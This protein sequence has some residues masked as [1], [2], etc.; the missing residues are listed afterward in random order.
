MRMIDRLD[1]LEILDI[2]TFLW[3]FSAK[4]DRSFN[5]TKLLQEIIVCKKWV[6]F[7]PNGKISLLSYI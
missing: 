1:G 7:F 3:Y 5:K 6:P 2:Q 4:I